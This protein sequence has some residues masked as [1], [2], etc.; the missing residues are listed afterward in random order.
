MACVCSRYNTRSDRPIG[1]H[2]F[3]VMPKGL[4]RA[5]KTRAKSHVI[6]NLLTSNVRSLREN[7]KPRPCRIDLAIAR[8]I[9][10]GL[11]LRFSR[12]D[13]ILG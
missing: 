1:G 8:S 9:Q 6:N 12:K 10:Q 5:P 11:G 3:L 2:Y 7:P 4:L 13:L